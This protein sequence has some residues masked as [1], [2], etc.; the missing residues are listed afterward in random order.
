MKTRTLRLRTAL[1]VSSLAIAAGTWPGFAA[2]PA[3][4]SAAEI[5]ELASV[6]QF[7]GLTDAELDQMQQ[8]LT[9]IRAMKPTERAALRAEIEKFRQ[10]PTAQREQLRQGW[11]WM[12]RDIQDGWRE[13]MQ[14]ATSAEHA[15]IQK[16]L[17]SLPPEQR[18]EYRRRMV[19]AYLKKK[20]E[21][22]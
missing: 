15:E 6:E 19:E 4:R 18:L 21:R 8:V 22:K 3:P 20:A 5:K 7:L 12:P 2:Q 16:T 1:V 9:R 11:G 17:Q 13:M 10:L 14:G